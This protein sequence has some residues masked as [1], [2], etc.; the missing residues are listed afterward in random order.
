[1]GINFG[2]IVK[3]A[4]SYVKDNPSLVG[5]LGS[6][7]LGTYDTVKGSQ[8]SARAQ[9]AIEGSYGERAPV[10]QRAIA[11]LTAAPPDLSAQFDDPGN[12]YARARK[13]RRQS[14]APPRA[15]G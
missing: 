15:D 13:A 9:R 10:R 8:A 14:S 1:M 6:A 12:P 11:E 5:A 7:A 2:K 3:K 4:V